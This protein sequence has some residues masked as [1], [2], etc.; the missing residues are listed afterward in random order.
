[1]SR[2]LNVEHLLLTNPE[3]AQAFYKATDGWIDKPRD[4][5]LRRAQDSVVFLANCKFSSGDPDS[6][7]CGIRST[8]IFGRIKPGKCRCIYG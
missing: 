1:M 2:K 4:G 6:L 8:M 7:I 5:E 3:P